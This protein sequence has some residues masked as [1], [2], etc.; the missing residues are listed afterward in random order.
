MQTDK[1]EVDKLWLANKIWIAAIVRSWPVA[2]VHSWSR[3]RKQ[4]FSIQ[5]SWSVINVY[6]HPFHVKSDHCTLKV[7]SCVL[8]RIS[9]GFLIFVKLAI[10]LEAQP[11]Q[12]YNQKLEKHWNYEGLFGKDK[13]DSKCTCVFGLQLWNIKRSSQVWSKGSNR[14]RTRPN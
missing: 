3:P 9:N 12:N 2:L 7:V 1:C 6:I 4:L 10:T 14:I 13:F 11:K 8:T 5:T